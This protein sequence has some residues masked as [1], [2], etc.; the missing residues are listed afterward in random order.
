MSNWDSDV[1]SELK[2]QQSMYRLHSYAHYDYYKGPVL[3]KKG[4]FFNKDKGNAIFE[5]LV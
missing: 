2:K 4:A 5:S 3:W 1:I